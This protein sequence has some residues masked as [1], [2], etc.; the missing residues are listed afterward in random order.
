MS[1]ITSVLRRYYVGIFVGTREDRRRM[2]VCEPVLVIGGVLGIEVVAKTGGFLEVV[3]R[4]LGIARLSARLRHVRGLP[5]M[6]GSSS[7]VRS[8]FIFLDDVLRS[9]IAT[10]T[11]RSVG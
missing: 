9:S 8:I 10:L 4:A 3:A 11:S 7:S 6:S 1:G 2:R 5:R